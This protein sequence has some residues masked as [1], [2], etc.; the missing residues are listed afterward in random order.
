MPI[1]RILAAAA[2]LGATALSVTGATFGVTHAFADN[3]VIH[4]ERV[5]H[6]ADNGVIH[7]EAVR[8][9]KAV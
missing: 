8:P 5:L 4:M 6:L 9:N 7:M 2:V 1:R 3:G